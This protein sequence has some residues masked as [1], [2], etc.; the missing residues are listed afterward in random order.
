MRAVAK[1]LAMA[2]GT[3]LAGEAYANAII[4]AAITPSDEMALKYLAKGLEF[5][6]KQLQSRS[7]VY[8]NGGIFYAG[9]GNWKE[10]L[11]HFNE[12]TKIAEKL[13]DRRMLEENM[14]FLSH[15]HHLMGALQECAKITNKTLVSAVS[16]SDLQVETIAL[17]AKVR[18]MLALG[19]VS[20]A[21]LLLPSAV[22]AFTMTGK[23]DVSSYSNFQGLWAMI[24]LHNLDYKRAFDLTVEASETFYK[25]EPTTFFSFP[26]YLGVLEVLVMLYAN[27][28]VIPHVPPRK[29][30]KQVTY[31]LR[32][33]LRFT[34][35]FAFAQ[36]R[37]YLWEGVAHFL[38][39]KYEQAL[40]SWDKSLDASHTF[41]MKYDEA[42]LHYYMSVALQD[43][44]NAKQQKDKSREQFSAIGIAFSPYF[45]PKV[46]EQ[47]FRLPEKQKSTLMKV[48]ERREKM[49]SKRK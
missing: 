13:G 8:Q 11:R 6:T 44:P 31:A 43:T 49:R 37:Y 16:R 29:L 28:S 35:V 22:K 34:A 5:S 2:D 48:I 26:G 7:M 41:G 47:L 21:S 42:L 9:R 39:G 46:M 19:F 18:D 38:N 36:P 27:R 33:V 45:G 24:S 3:F 1:S 10:A 40:D 4:A 32:D 30:A 20:E 17:L 15:V 25:T 14:L 12:S 23:S